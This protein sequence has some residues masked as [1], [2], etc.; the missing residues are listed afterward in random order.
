M[1]Q[2]TR[3]ELKEVQMNILDALVRFC[4][5]NGLRVSISSGT[6]IGAV[7]HKGYIPWDDDIDVYMLRE[8]YVKL[9]E[10]LP[11]ILDNTYKL[12][13]IYR[14]DNWHLSFAK[15]CDIRTISEPKGRKTSQYGAFIDIFPVDAV[16]DNHREFRSYMRKLGFIKFLFNNTRTT[17]PEMSWIKKIMV[18]LHN[19]IISFIPNKSL[20]LTREKLNQKYNGMG[21]SSVYANSYG[22]LQPHPFPRSFF[23]NIV[24]WDFEDRKVPGFKDAEE[25]LTLQYGDFMKLPPEEKR[26]GHFETIYWID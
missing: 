1:R 5:D 26:I 16:P 24:D 10:L 2:L 21:Y 14:N 9:E 22:P 17:T 23:D 20:V 12:E 6:L 15:L 8:D 3:N 11:H 13:S 25:F 19:R 4:I 7:R 18:I